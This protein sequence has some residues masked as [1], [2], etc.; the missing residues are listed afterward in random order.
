MFPI[1]SEKAKGA[2]NSFLQTE[3]SRQQRPRMES[4]GAGGT[5]K[6]IKNLKWSKIDTIET[7][8][9]G[10]RENRGA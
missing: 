4:R 6:S 2:K 3:G 9:P 5:E 8:D 7:L 10:G 1:E